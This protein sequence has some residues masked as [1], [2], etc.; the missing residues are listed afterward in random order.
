M[1]VFKFKCFCEDNYVGMTSKQFGKRI[2]EH[3]Q[4]SI[5]EFCK[6]NIEEYKSIQ[7]V[8][9]L[10]IYAIAEHVVINLDCASNYNL[11][12]LIL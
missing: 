1:V 11:K 3:I 12:K 8:N 4:K 6:V 10:K 7:V 9:A 2:K 5:V